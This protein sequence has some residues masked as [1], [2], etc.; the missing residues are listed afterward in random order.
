MYIF[1][2]IEIPFFHLSRYD[3][4]NMADVAEKATVGGFFVFLPSCFPAVE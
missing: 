3:T 4:E 1:F 2:C